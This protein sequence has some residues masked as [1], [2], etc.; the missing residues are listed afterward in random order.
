MEHVRD[1]IILHYHANQRDEPMW[2][3]CR[4]MELPESLAVRLRAWRDRAHAWQG[5]DELFRIDSWTHVLLGQGIVPQQHHP[6][7]RALPDENMRKLFDSIRQPID[8]AIAQMP[9]QQEFIDRYCKAAPEVWAAKAA[10]AAAM[11]RP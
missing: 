4:E 7:T 1:F 9:P 2:K 3:E 10:K 8:R 6:I 5:A 11:E